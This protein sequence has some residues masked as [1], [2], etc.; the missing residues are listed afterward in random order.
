M[1]PFPASIIARIWIQARVRIPYP[2]AFDAQVV[3]AF[4]PISSQTR[5]TAPKER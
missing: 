3:T 2:V 1:K 5:E 4:D